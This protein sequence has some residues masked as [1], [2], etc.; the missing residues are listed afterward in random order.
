[1]LTTTLQSRW[2][3]PFTDKEIE[4]PRHSMAGMPKLK[5]KLQ[6][7]RHLTLE[8]SCIGC[9]STH[10]SSALESSLLPLRSIWRHRTFYFWTFAWPSSRGGPHTQPLSQWGKDM[11]FPCLWSW[12]W[13]DISTLGQQETCAFSQPTE[14]RDSSPY[15]LTD[16]YASLLSPGWP[17]NSQLT[18]LPQHPHWRLGV[19]HIPLR[20]RTNLTTEKSQN[21]WPWP[22]MEMCMKRPSALAKLVYSLLSSLHTHTQR[23][24]FP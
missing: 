24:L 7:P 13:L 15:L 3:S 17:T 9:H 18:V 20:L 10:F 19:H 21:S 11:S 16:T 1:M 14:H 4:V 2:L 23:I 12:D 22:L 8:L 6:A 5:V